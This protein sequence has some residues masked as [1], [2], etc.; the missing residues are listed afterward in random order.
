MEGATT[1]APYKFKVVLLGEG[2]VGKSSLM[3]R[4]VENKFSPRH[5]STVQAACLT[6]KVMV[7]GNYVDLNIWDTAGQE[8][9]HALGPMYYRDSQGALLIYDITD[10]RSFEKVKVWVK[11]LRGMLKDSV[12]LMIIGNKT[13]LERER[14][15]ESSAAK[16]Y[17]DSVGAQYSETSAKENLGIS[18]VFDQ[19]TKLMIER[20]KMAISSGVE[21]P[22]VSTRRNR[23]ILVVEDDPT[24][25]RK[26]C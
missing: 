15:I 14:V 11:E 21:S 22:S 25:S 16:E 9:F 13:D 8:R 24:P 17:A 19:V 23:N 10:Q 4:Y 5:L 3:L 6:K 20:K 12:T 18:A 7:D 2:A 1:S 26:C